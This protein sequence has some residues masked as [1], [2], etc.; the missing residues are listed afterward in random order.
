MALSDELPKGNRRG[1][2]ARQ[3]LAVAYQSV[4]DTT[5]ADAAIVLVHLAKESGF[6]SVTAP[7][8]SNETLQR[9]EG[10]RAVFALI[11]NRLNMTPDEKQWLAEAVRNEV[12]VSIEEQRDIP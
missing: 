12:F 2:T 6:F 1:P 4:F 7:G 5:R 3:R 8:T 11:W 10:G 9:A